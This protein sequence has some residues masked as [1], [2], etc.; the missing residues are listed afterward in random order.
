VLTA[1]TGLFFCGA[2]MPCIWR[3]L[4]KV[5]VRV[6]VDQGSQAAHCRV[7]WSLRVTPTLSHA[8]AQSA[9]HWNSTKLLS[10]GVFRGGHENSR[11]CTRLYIRIAHQK[12]MRVLGTYAWRSDFKCGQ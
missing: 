10:C 5:T 2:T 4:R 6:Q 9:I 12:S 11:H 7:Q 3:C 8:P 1:F